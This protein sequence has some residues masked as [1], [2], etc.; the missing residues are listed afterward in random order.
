M[1]NKIN[2]ECSKKHSMDRLNQEKDI[3]ISSSNSS[4][5]NKVYT[6]SNYRRTGEKFLPRI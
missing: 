3:V 4:S 5:N 2:L 6:T 1:K